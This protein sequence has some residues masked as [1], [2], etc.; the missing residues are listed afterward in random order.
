MNVDGREAH[1]ADL[2]SLQEWLRRLQRE[3]HLVQAR[4][5]RY[6]D[7]NYVQVNGRKSPLTSKGRRSLYVRL[8]IPPLFADAVCDEEIRDF[9]VNSLLRKSDQVL[10]IEVIDERIEGV[11]PEN[12]VPVSNAHVLR[13]LLIPT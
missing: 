6:V 13:Q 7:D 3:E 4:Q 1:F 2:L 9:L 8:G 12:W 10:R 5:L 11:L